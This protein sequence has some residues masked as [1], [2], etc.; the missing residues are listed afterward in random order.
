MTPEDV[1]RLVREVAHHA[2]DLEPRTGLLR[3]L[4]NRLVASGFEV[5]TRFD[6]AASSVERSL[7]GDEIRHVRLNPKV[8]VDCLWDLA[9]EV[10]HLDDPPENADPV[11]QLLR[12]QRAWEA[13]WRQLVECDPAIQGSRA[14][15]DRRRDE[16]LKGYQQ[17]ASRFADASARGQ[18]R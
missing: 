7:D 17:A 2:P 1:D 8:G 15:Y 13:G 14:D 16:C 6:I 11:E 9:H 4:L 3:C 10:G 18:E 5:S 12:E